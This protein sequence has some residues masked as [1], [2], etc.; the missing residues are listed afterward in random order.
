VLAVV[1]NPKSGGFIKAVVAVV[2]EK[3]VVVESIISI[4]FNPNLS[5]LVNI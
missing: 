3:S 4:Y 1:V 5:I 2:S